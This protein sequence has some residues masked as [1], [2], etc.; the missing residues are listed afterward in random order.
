MN[1]HF[2]QQ[3]TTN[4][5]L[6]EKL[7]VL[8]EEL[9][10]KPDHIAYKCDGDEPYD[11]YKQNLF[12]FANELKEIQHNG[13]RISVW[14]LQ[15]PV[16][17]FPYIELDVQVSEMQPGERIDHFAFVI[18]NITEALTAVQQLGLTCTEIRHFKNTDYFKI[19]APNIIIELRTQSIAA[20]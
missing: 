6:P 12:G 14:E 16:Q 8:L 9:Q 10:A 3:Q 7:A 19:F 5:A 13:R 15:T 20:N 11:T 1:Y 2:V 17:D 4:Y 18:T